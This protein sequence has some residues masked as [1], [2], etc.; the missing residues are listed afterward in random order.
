MTT[1]DAIATARLA[2]EDALRVVVASPDRNGQSLARD[3][4]LIHHLAGALRRLE[5]ARQQLGVQQ[6]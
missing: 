1:E 6:P 2:V 3:A 5:R 4:T